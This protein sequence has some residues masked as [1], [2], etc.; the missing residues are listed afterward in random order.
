MHSDLEQ[1]L[2]SKEEIVQMVKNLAQQISEDYRKENSQ[3]IIVVGILKG[4]LFFTADLAREISLPCRMEFMRVKSYGLS[5]KTSG[6]VQIRQDIE[7]DIEGKDVLLCEDLIDTGL[8]KQQLLAMLKRHNP[9]SLKLCAL[10]S[11]PS[12][13]LVDVKL[14]YVAAEVP[15]EFIVGYGMDF[16]EQ[17]RNLPDIGILKRSIY[18]R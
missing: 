3:E 6:N 13:R 14:D 1:I 4:A 2:F 12:R 10:L 18:E 15:D 17:Y 7:I 16:A 5:S 9:R 11:K 8:T